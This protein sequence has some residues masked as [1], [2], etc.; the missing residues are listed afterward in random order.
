MVRQTGPEPELWL[1]DVAALLDLNPRWVQDYTAREIVTPREQAVGK[2]G[3]NTYGPTELVQLLTAQR[4]VSDGMPRSTVRDLFAAYRNASTR[5]IHER[6]RPPKQV[7]PHPS[8]HSPLDGSKAFDLI[9]N[10]FPRDADV[11]LRLSNPEFGICVPEELAQWP[12]FWSGV[13]HRVPVVPVVPLPRG[14]IATTLHSN[15]QKDALDPN[16]RDT[17]AKYASLEREMLMKLLMMGV[18]PDSFDDLFTIRLLNVA[19]LKERVARCLVDNR[20]ISD[21]GEVTDADMASPDK[22]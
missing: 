7:P 8:R 11:L 16:N 17:R 21:D 4:L 13:V 5:V 19:T 12:T 10:P 14:Y 2:G 18:N 20:W 6:E 15:P 3:R 22:G 1:K 9:F